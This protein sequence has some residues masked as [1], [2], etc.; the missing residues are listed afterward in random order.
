MSKPIKNGITLLDFMKFAI[1]AGC[2]TA[3]TY[4]MTTNMATP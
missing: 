1:I 2:A 3:I 4:A